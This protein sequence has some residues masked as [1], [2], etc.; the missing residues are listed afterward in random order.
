M[1]KRSSNPIS[2]RVWGLK[3]LFVSKKVFHCR[4]GNVGVGT[5]I[6]EPVEDG[7]QI[8]ISV[9]DRVGQRISV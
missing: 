1:D 9:R 7:V 6:P 3:N 5:R 2:R 4:G 8:L